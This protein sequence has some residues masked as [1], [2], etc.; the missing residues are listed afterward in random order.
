MLRTR[1]DHCLRTLVR[2]PAA[3]ARLVCLPHSGGSAAGYGPWSTALPPTVELL[4]VQYPGHGDRFGEPPSTDVRALSAEL[5][6]ELLRLP[7][8]PTVLFGHSLGAL[9]G[10]ETAVTLGTLG[11]PPAGLLASSCPPP[12]R[13]GRIRAGGLSDEVLWSLIRSLGGIDP[14]LPEEP[15]V[16]EAVLPVLRA[17]LTAHEQYRV[18]PRTAPL[19]CPVRCHHGT[20]DPLVDRALVAEWAAVTTGP[21]SLLE[22]EGHHFH[23]FQHPEG[24]LADLAAFLDAVTVDAV[25]VDA[26]ATGATAAPAPRLPAPST[27]VPSTAVP[28]TADPGDSTPGDSTPRPAR[29]L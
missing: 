22:R 20:L 28:S 3:T 23:L 8:L 17:D 12:G 2:A 27:A 26:A 13:A 7:P 15:E 9:V 25:T 5:A 11:R 1:R 16:A 14:D 24:V 29:A 19:A 10:Y 6:S 21:F 4:A 18:E